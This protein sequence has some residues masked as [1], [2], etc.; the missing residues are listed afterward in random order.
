LIR[1]LFGIGDI[2]IH[3]ELLKNTICQKTIISTLVD[4]SRLKT[5]EIEFSSF[6]G[7]ELEATLYHLFAFC[8]TNPQSHE[9]ILSVPSV[10][11]NLVIPKSE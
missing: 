5:T 9:K 7:F 2:F 8:T 1:N 10:V 11:V 6:Q 3:W 4:F